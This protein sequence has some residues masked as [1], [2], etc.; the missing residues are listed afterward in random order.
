[1]HIMKSWEDMCCPLVLRRTAC[2]SHFLR[3]LW[4]RNE[5]RSPVLS[6]ACLSCIY[7]GRVGNRWVVYLC[8]QVWV[9][10]WHSCHRLHFS[11]LQHNQL[12]DCCVFQLLFM[13]PCT[14]F[15]SYNCQELIRNQKKWHKFI[16]MFILSLRTF[17]ETSDYTFVG[18][19]N[20]STRL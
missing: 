5:S 13:L 6:R 14:L 10:L 11:L 18:T 15:S 20:P 1:M 2:S 12:N 17:Q 4:T 16:L 7:V 8:N 3:C 19:D 9:Y